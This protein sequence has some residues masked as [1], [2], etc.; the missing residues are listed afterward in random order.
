MQGVDGIGAALF[1]VTIYALATTGLFA[2]LLYLGRA[3]QEIEGVDDLAGVGRTA[4]LAGLA[5]S[6]FLFSLAGIPPLPG[7]W[8]KLTLILAHWAFATATLNGRSRVG[9]WPSRWWRC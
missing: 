1:Y 6:V 9:F 3:G 7:F 8:G 2:A 5:L 4:P